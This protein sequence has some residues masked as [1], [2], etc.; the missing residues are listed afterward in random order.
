LG[1]PARPKPQGLLNVSPPLFFIGVLQLKVDIKRNNSNTRPKSKL[2]WMLKMA[3]ITFLIAIVFAFVSELITATGSII[4]SVLVLIFLVVI[5]CLFDIIGTAVAAADLAPFIA[6]SS[7]KV[8]GS[9]ES[10][11]LIKNA[12]K[13]SN[14]CN[15]V[16]GDICGIVSGAAMAAIIISIVKNNSAITDGKEMWLSIF[17]AATVSAVTVGCKAFG[18]QLAMRRSKDIIHLCGYLIS[19]LKRQE[20]K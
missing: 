20:K 3:G 6:M 5:H 11:I 4:F 12:E 19:L 14:V 18:K 7:R 2:K 15:D 1:K 10:V 13:V 8:R 9:R 16:I 17:F